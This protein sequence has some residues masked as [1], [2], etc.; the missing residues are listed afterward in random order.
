M[1]RIQTPQFL[2]N[3]YRD[4]RDRRMLLPAIALVVA[5]IAVPILLK[6]SSSSTAPP[7]AAPT[8]DTGKESATEPAVLTEEL[9]VTNY[10]KRLD[11][12][13]TKNPFRR[14][15]TA[16]P[17]SSKLTTT[18]TGGTSSTT[19]SVTTG[20]STGSGA[21]P[22]ATASGTSTTSST[23]E[24][25]SSGTGSGST[26][27]HLV[28]FTYEVSVAI[29]RPGHLTH[30]SKVKRLA[31]LPN[32]DKP[33]VAFLGVTSDVKGALF[34]ISE[35]V[36]S[37]RGDGR[38]FPRRSSCTYLELELGGEAKLKYAPE[39]DRT[40]KLKLLGFHRAPFHAGGTGSG[41]RSSLPSLAPGG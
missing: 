26:E 41:K 16:L 33:M 2:N 34:S 28:W 25:P 30:R 22:S 7:P 29:G 1:K 9:G 17:K 5:L 18:S 27:P 37:V 6:S 40:Y 8:A 20:T 31:L 32:E 3:L 24:P 36:S 35:D 38:C 10:R 23:S 19:T 39:G 4:M 21:L 13:Q 11:R 14:H 15:F 12:L